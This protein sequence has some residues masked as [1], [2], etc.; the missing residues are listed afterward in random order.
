MREWLRH[1]WY[2][3]VAVLRQW[4]ALATAGVVVGLVAVVEHLTNRAIAGWP[5]WTA[6]ISSLFAAFVSV[7]R[8]ERLNWEQLGGLPFLSDTPKEIVGVFK[9]RTSTQAQKLARAYE[10]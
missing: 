9:D 2:F 6:I 5:L 3:I 10:G 7:W 4:G 8:K 1:L